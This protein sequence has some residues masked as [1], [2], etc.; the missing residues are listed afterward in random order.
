MFTTR[1]AGARG[2]GGAIVHRASPRG[3]GRPP[4]TWPGRRGGPAAEAAPTGPRRARRAAEPPQGP[5]LAASTGAS[6]FSV[7]ADSVVWPSGGGEN[8]AIAL[9][10]FCTRDSTSVAP[11]LVRKR[12]T[13]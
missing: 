11:S 1:G 5:Q 3:P 8:A 2:G 12:S 10:R 9:T 7:A 6:E 4:W 13:R